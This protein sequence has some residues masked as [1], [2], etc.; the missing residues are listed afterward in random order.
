MPFANAGMLVTVS[1]SIAPRRI[2]AMRLAEEEA[3]RLATDIRDAGMGIV[4]PPAPG[5]PI[6]LDR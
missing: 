1:E 4:L 6:A 2:V 5:S 3:A